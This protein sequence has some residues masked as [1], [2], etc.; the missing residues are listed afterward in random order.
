[1]KFL[2][3]SLNLPE[4]AWN[5]LKLPQTSLNSPWISLKFP[6]SP[7][8]SLKLLQKSLNL[9]L[10]LP[11][12]PWISLN[13]SETPS[14]V[15]ESPCNS[16]KPLDTPWNSL[17][18]SSQSLLVR[19]FHTVSMH[20]TLVFFFRT[21]FKEFCK[22]AHLSCML[23]WYISFRSKFSIMVFLSLNSNPT[24][25]TVAATRWRFKEN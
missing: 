24:N 12:S 21:L 5:P 18:S 1:M 6:E 13:L 16:L 22:H 11:E 9:D 7:W 23:L 2:Q 20:R 4:T 10:K 17:K 15:P 3:K 14:K 8:N 25:Y 19:L